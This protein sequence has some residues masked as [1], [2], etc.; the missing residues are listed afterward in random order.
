MP[1]GSKL[2]AAICLAIL[3]AIVA[4]MVKPLMSEGINFGHFTYVT[5]ILGLIVGWVHLGKRAGGTMTDGINNGITAVVILVVFALFVFGSYEMVDQALRHR[6]STMMEAMRGILE[7]G[8]EYGQYL[9]DVEIIATLFVGAVLSGM[10]T[11][12]AHRRWR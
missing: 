1:T 5:A 8:M 6:Y 9:I 10:I 2:V 12:Y 7:I 4:E 3:G 11:E